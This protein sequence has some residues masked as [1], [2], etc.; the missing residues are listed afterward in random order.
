MG[1]W[2]LTHLMKWD[3][4]CSDRRVGGLGVRHL[5]LL[6][7][8]LLCKWIWR[9]AS[10]REAFWRQIISGKYGNLEGD[11]CSKE[12]R[13]GYGVGLWKTIRKLWDVISSKLSFSVGNGKRI[14]FWKDKW[15]GDEPLNVS[16]PS[17]FALSNSKDDWVMELWQLSNEGGGWNPNFLRPLNDWEIV[18]VECF[19]ARLQDKVVEEGILRC[20]FLLGRWFGEKL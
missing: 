10:E 2:D 5:H 16:F 14:K 4:V 12:V 15:C 17:L 1:R 8:A 9:F 3:T 19:L 11:W 6:N 18:I 7:K 13:G 20:A